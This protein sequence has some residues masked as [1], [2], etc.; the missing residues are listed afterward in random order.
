MF[1]F[2]GGLLVGAM[3]CG[4]LANCFP[5]LFGIAVAAVNKAD[6]AINQKI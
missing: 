3:A 6:A 5:S 1:Y 2:I 4:V